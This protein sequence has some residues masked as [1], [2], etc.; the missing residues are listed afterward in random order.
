MLNID[1]AHFKYSDN[2]AESIKN[3]SIR[4]NKGEVILLCGE[5]GCG[6]T[7]LIR[8]ING[9]IPHFYEGEKKGSVL[10][11]G[12]DVGGLP[13]HESGKLIGSVFQNPKSQF[14]N[15]DTTSEIVFA[16]EN[17]G[18]PEGTINN[19]LSDTIKT[20]NISNLI[21]RN[22][23][24]LSGG[25]KQK[26]ACAS[27]YAVGPEILVLDEP[28]SSLDLCSIEHLK[29]IIEIW[30]SQGKT[31]IIS[32]HRLHYLRE[33]IDEVFYIKEGCLSS[34]YSGNDFRNLDKVTIESL[35]L[36]PLR[37]EHITFRHSYKKE[38]IDTESH[39]LELN[40]FHFSYNKGTKVLDIPK[41]KLS[42][43]NATAIIGKNGSGKS[44]FGR[45]LC[46][47]M[48]KFNGS[49]KLGDKVYKR[50]DILRMSY[51]VMQDVNHQLFTESVLDELLLGMEVVNHEVAEEILDKL[52]LLSLKDK[53]PLSLSG[54]QRQRVA[55]ASAIAS[56]KEILIFDEPTSGL[57]LRHMKEVAKI[58]AF[59]R[60]IG[61]TVVII[62]H[63]LEFIFNTCT[64]I[65]HIEKG[66]V[67]DHY[68][69]NN[70]TEEKLKNTFINRFNN[71]F[72]S[73]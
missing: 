59:L 58:I 12:M 50:K 6:K 21:D 33:L 13:L 40:N 71:R 61:K 17:F 64:Q 5:S 20:F 37:L 31:I 7:T 51:M 34:H 66:C 72:S 16:C 44:T 25:E 47:L 2:L 53:H 11:K 35:G 26:I 1:N 28:S 54:G 22:I 4:I 10:Y 9:L 3:I 55:I 41:L 67:I 56:N 48:K 18:F 60:T 8:L 49:I 19:I 70:A 45:C 65:I 23:F 36:R 38:L 68:S 57:D 27:V 42:R 30:K 63:D 52:D 14:Y 69:L 62:S 46:G 32:E 24:E 39:N 73:F 15:V 43:S 29:G